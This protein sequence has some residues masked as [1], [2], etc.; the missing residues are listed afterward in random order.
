MT[1]P[2]AI[3]RQTPAKRGRCGVA[4]FSPEYRIAMLGPTGSGKTSMIAALYDQFDHVI[5]AHSNLSLIAEAGTG[6]KLTR[7]LAD[8][9]RAA[10]GRK[11]Q[12]VDTGTVAGS[13]NRQ[14]Y[15]FRLDH[16]DSDANLRIVFDDYPGSWMAYS[17]K[18]VQE[19]VE[20]ARV[21]LVAIDAPAL[22][23]LPASLYIEHYRPQQV[24]DLL[25]NVIK[26]VQNHSI[27][28]QDM[29]VL[30]VATKCERWMI[31]G[32][33]ETLRNK[34]SSTYSKALRVMKSCG[35]NG[36]FLPIQ[37]LGSVAFDR[38]LLNNDGASAPKPIYVK[39][40]DRDYAPIDCDQPLRYA[41]GHMF[42]N[43]REEAGQKREEISATIRNRTMWK[44]MISWGK[45]KF[46]LDHE[47]NE[48]LAWEQRAEVLLAEAHRFTSQNKVSDGFAYFKYSKAETAGVAS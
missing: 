39:V 17:P 24:S 34:F 3:L 37:T 10:E 46:G 43:L 45:N 11:G 40:M 9:R 29:L 19:I 38:Y 25:Y 31:T 22:M 6:P 48:M 42:N 1:T 44:R 20:K 28:N 4:D 7:H 47:R 30:F 27:E 41:L 15:A 36:A 8:L 33:G 26:H 21:V 12:P 32:E 35:V 5:G 18:V 14:E 16:L 23:A 13:R 2:S